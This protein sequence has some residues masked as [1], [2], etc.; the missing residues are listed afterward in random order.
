VAAPLAM[1]E[2]LM[3]VQNFNGANKTQSMVNGYY[4]VAAR[5]TSLQTP[6]R[7]YW[8]DNCAATEN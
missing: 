1:Q 8:K 5:V 2:Y 7:K 3:G 4:P 6:Q